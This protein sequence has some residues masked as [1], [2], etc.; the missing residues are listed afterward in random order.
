MRNELIV[1]IS[2]GQG[3]VECKKVVAL[4]FDKLKFAAENSG[5]KILNLTKVPAENAG[6]YHSINFRTEGENM[7][8]FINKWKGT[9]LWQGQSSFRK[10]IKRKNWFVGIEVFDLPEKIIFKLE[11]LIFETMRASGPGGQYVNKTESA[12]RVYH[13]PSGISYLSMEARSQ[14]Q[15]KINCI[16]KIKSKL[17]SIESDS[18]WVARINVD[19]TQNTSAGRC[20]NG[21]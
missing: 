2:S 11:D 4:V 5:I 18:E 14:H 20:C 17:S 3:P 10:N 19:G 13:K 1:Q 8:E 16:E 15:N 9:I 21:F 7:N 12:V 6:T